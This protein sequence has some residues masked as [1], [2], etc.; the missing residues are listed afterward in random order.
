MAGKPER[1]GQ[2]GLGRVLV[3][4]DEDD[5]RELLDMT[6]SRMG[7]DA[8]C[9]AN[10]AE[11]R[12]KKKKKTYELCLTDMRLPDGSGLDVLAYLKDNGLRPRV[13]MLTGVGE[14]SIAIRSMKLGA[15]EYIT[16]PFKLEDL[17][18]AIEKVLKR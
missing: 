4:D 12:R 2:P 1:R 8:D 10:V 15:N 7:L 5:I 11:A 18:A 6:L 13:I 9:A 3:V 16:K 17:T 14:L